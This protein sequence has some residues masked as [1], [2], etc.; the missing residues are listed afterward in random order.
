MGVQFKISYHGLGLYEAMNLRNKVLTNWQVVL[1]KC[2][3]ILPI[4]NNLQHMWLNAILHFHEHKMIEFP[5]NLH[6]SALKRQKYCDKELL[7]EQNIVF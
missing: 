7:E 1:N 5:F 2:L 4:K 6:H 3:I